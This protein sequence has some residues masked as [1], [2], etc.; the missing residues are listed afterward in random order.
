MKSLV[1]LMGCVLA[2]AGARCGVRTT[3]DLVTITSRI[4]HEGLSFLT[5]TL[6]AFCADFERSLA[7]G[8]VDPSLFQGFSRKEGLPRFLGGFLDLVFDR[9]SAQLLEEPDHDAIQSVRQL[10]LLVGK[11][12]S[13][14]SD[15][16][17]RRAIAGYLQCEKEVREWDSKVGERDLSLFSSAFFRLWGDACS[18]IDRKVD[19]YQLVPRHGPGATADHLQGN[20]KY[21]QV[22]W[23]TRLER[24]FPSADFL[25]PN[26]RYWEN[27]ARVRFLEPREER[28]VKVTLVPKTP[29]TP[30]IIAIEPTCMQYTQQALLR[31][32]SALIDDTSVPSIVGIRDQVPNQEMARV[33]SIDGS[34]ATLDLSEASD[35]VSNL[36]VRR[37]FRPWT[38]LSDALQASRSL[39]A[40][41]PGRTK[42]IYLAKFASMGSAV[43]FPVEAMVFSA[44]VLVAI[45]DQLNCV[46]TQRDIQSLRGRVRV[47]GDD[48]IVPVEYALSVT[49]WLSVFGLKV[50]SRKSFWT[51]KFRESCGK[52]YYGGDDVSVVRIR[53]VAPSSRRNA[54][55]VMSWASSRNQFYRA[56]Y[57]KTAAHIDRLMSKIGPWPAVSPT[58]QALGRHS[59]LGYDTEKECPRLHRPLV[60]AMI[61]RSRSPIDSLS[62]EG[63]LMKFFLLRGREPMEQED[64]LERY[65]RPR[66]VHIKTGWSSSV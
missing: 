10:C 43:C 37:A 24:V 22:E 23:T 48:I 44:I 7:E 4:E 47:Y 66:S 2:D 6:P 8:R 15:A 58:S 33:G 51:G 30:R 65:G 36:L 27:L 64:H 26:Y 13:R 38:H 29:K 1:D 20:Q 54:T 52:E 16:R 21:R 5:I 34:L 50:N 40:L 9:R 53:E 62:D 56:G 14:C 60:R 46:L 28:P 12:H 49:H 61:P 63:A 45:E 17:N 3:R 19:A 35:R 59:F 55:E 25:I 41:V 39:R 57:W 18:L 31:E 32:I 11:L 42:P